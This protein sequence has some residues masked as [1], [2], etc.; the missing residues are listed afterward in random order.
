MF[1]AAGNSLN[2]F[3]ARQVLIH[4]S[5]F[6]RITIVFLVRTFR[7]PAGSRF[8]YSVS[9]STHSPRPTRWPEICRNIFFMLQERHA[10]IFRQCA[11][12]VKRGWEIAD[13]GINAD[14]CMNKRRT[15]TTREKFVWMSYDFMFSCQFPYGYIYWYFNNWGLG[16]EGEFILF[17]PCTALEQGT[18]DS[19]S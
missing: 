12:G 7:I 19:P 3:K 13:N 10:H 2:L 14:V 9:F 1:S 5:L 17:S 16:F 18:I 6:I 4:G 15:C 11:C 8:R